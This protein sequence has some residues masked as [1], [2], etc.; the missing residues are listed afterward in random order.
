ML[1]CGVVAIFLAT[2]TSAWL[3]GIAGLNMILAS[4][5]LLFT[6]QMPLG[7]RTHSLSPNDYVLAAL[8]IYFDIIFFDVH[9]FIGISQHL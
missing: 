4:F 7:G 5:C 9:T 2:H 3:Y 1:V 6:L 8:N